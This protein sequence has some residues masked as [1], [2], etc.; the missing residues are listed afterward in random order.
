MTSSLL[1]SA[2]AR[3]PFA[4]L[5]GAQNARA[6]LAVFVALTFVAGPAVANPP[7]GFVR[8]VDVAPGVVQDIRYA[9][10]G[11]FTGRN[12]QTRSGI[13]FTNHQQTL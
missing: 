13:G 6:A 4:A 11:N 7:R 12:E 9:G 2:I 3:D 1:A 5:A 8:L 10:A